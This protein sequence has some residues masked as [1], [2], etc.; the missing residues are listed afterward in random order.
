MSYSIYI[1]NAELD[2]DIE[3]LRARYIVKEIEHPCAPE[4]PGK[5]DI[6]GKTNGRHG[7]HQGRK[8]RIRHRHRGQH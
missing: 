8:G 2:T 7:V 6:S 3:S 4:F 5:G 1:G